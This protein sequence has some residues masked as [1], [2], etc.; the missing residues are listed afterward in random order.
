[1]K[2]TLSRSVAGN[3]LWARQGM[4]FLL[5]GLSLVVTDWMVFV[6]LTAWGL[7]TPMANVTARFVGALMGFVA[8]GRWTFSAHL[9]ARRL[10]RYLILWLFMTA[11]STGLVSTITI[12]SSLHGSWLAKLLI[13]ATLAVVSFWIS[14]RWVYRMP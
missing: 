2:A 1:M 11:L 14:R 10:A 13:E 9:S 5:I 6:V 12:H 4:T 3:T 7:N 8:N